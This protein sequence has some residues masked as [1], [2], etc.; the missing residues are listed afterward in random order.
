MI[1]R[2]FEFALLQR[3]TGLD[4]TAAAEEIEALVR[5][6]VLRVVGERFDFVHDRVREVVHGQLLLPRRVLLHAAVASALEGLPA[7]D[8]PDEQVE[9]LAHH[10][11]RGELWEKAVV[12][13]QRAGSV[14]AD[15][16]ASGQAGAC[17]DQALEALARLP[18]SR[19][20][21]ERGIELRRLRSAH[22]FALGEREG[23]LRCTQEA[24]ALAERL[25]DQP[26]L[27]MVVATRANALWFA[28]DNPRAL[29]AGSR[30]AIREGGMTVGSGVVSEVLE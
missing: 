23:V 2:E 28:G 25:G 19:E 15:C 3:A 22:H 20:T 16:S 12:Y 24:I 1:G 26:R 6:R 29:E 17:F 9:R 14:A 10:T 11:F 27:A 13:G 5:R 4:E 7:G 8:R 18:E 21:L 30:F